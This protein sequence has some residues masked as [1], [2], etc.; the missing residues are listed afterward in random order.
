MIR[1]RV[2]SVVRMPTV[3]ACAF[4]ACAPLA[5]RAQQSAAPAH[6]KVCADGV[7]EYFSRS[8]LPTPYDTLALPPAEPIRVTSP[9]EAAAAQ[10]MMRERAGSVGATGL[11]VQEVTEE[12]PDGM[13]MQRSVSAIFAPSDTAR[14]YA[15]CRASGKPAAP[16]RY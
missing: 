12:T 5:L 1:V 10:R 2:A 16:S 7:R 6:P 13:R 3:L 9:E 8:E 14:A 11:F 15:A 4:A